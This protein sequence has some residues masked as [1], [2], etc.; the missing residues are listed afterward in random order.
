M[1]PRIVLAALAMAFIFATV[2]ATVTTVS[3]TTDK[4][5]FPQTA[6]PTWR[7]GVTIRV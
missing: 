1:V 4:L 7:Y 5:G 2:A 6:N 3:N